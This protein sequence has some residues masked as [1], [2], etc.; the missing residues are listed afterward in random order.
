MLELVD[1]ST[2]EPH[3]RFFYAVYHITEIPTLCSIICINIYHKLV[4]T[5]LVAWLLERSYIYEGNKT[6]KYFLFSCMPIHFLSSHVTAI[7]NLCA[8]S[9]KQIFTQC[10]ELHKYIHHVA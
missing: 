8:C 10:I 4:L 6:F 2:S 3:A 5:S 7:L 1:A 9:R